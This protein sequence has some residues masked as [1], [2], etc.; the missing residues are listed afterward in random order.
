MTQESLIS[1]S[2]KGVIL[3]HEA[4]LSTQYPW[5]AGTESTKEISQTKLLYIRIELSALTTEQ[6]I[7]FFLVNLK[8]YCMLQG[9]PIEFNTAIYL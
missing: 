1:P 5:V 6:K 3:I 4:Q 8:L 2:Q 7:P 9:L